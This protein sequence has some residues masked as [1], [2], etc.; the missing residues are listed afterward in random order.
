MEGL[1][2]NK[3]TF[4]DMF[5]IQKDILLCVSSDAVCHLQRKFIEKTV[6]MACGLVLY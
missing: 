5:A 2:S 1:I 6:V 4:M 3:A